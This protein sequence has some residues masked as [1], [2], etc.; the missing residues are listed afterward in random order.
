MNSQSGLPYAPDVE[1]LTA[2]AVAQMWDV[3]PGYSIDVFDKDEL[4]PSVRGN[5]QLAIDVLRR[6]Q[7]PGH[8]DLA[9]ARQLG[10]RR[11]GQSVP[12]ESVI[13]A[14][15]STERVIILDLFARSDDWAASRATRFADLV[16]TTFDLLTDE[17]IN[18]Y[19]ETSSAMDAARR[20]AENEIVNAFVGG[21][22]PEAA[23]LQQWS[24]LL[25]ID[26]AR[27]WMALAVLVDDDDQ[28]AVHS[29][30]R[31]LAAK[32]QPLTAGILF[33]DVGRATVI[34]V[35]PRAHDAADVR[36]T[37]RTA[38]ELPGGELR[39]SCGTGEVV[40]DLSGL[41]ESC[42]Q[43]LEAVAAAAVG[44]SGVVIFDYDDALVDVL[45]S[46]VPAA[47]QR[48]AASRLAPLRPH[49]Q[50]LETLHALY[51]NHLSQ[52][53]TARQLFVHVNTVTHRLGR[54]RELTGRD[55]MRVT[56]LVE[57]A[58]ALRWLRSHAGDG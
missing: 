26:P 10:S 40:D 22:V 41:S 38:L 12:L 4:V 32:L 34:L 47:A 49:P 58:L 39:I 25:K 45:L 33:G 50:L 37:L 17:M 1:A 15:R 23:Q 35:A 11:A 52:S 19:R 20:R 46:G 51:D 7:V 57:F 43:A 31:R 54:I 44:G 53:A 14:Y 6:D 30:R 24:R 56:H 29:L 55:P 28:L 16:I 36:E 48:L 27:P 18:G 9:D 3:Y 13:Q 21:V 42:R 5:V 2:E 8:R